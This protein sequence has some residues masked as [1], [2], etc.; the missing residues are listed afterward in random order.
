MKVTQDGTVSRWEPFDEGMVREDGS[1]ALS[2]PPV[3]TLA[4]LGLL[5]WAASGLRP[6]TMGGGGPTGPRVAAIGG[7]GCSPRRPYPTSPFCSFS[8]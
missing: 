1:L 6:D 7:S 5:A 4:A 8:G 2:L 3:S